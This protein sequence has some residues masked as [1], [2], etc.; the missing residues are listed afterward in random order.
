MMSLNKD[1]KYAT[2][3]S[4]SSHIWFPVHI[5]LFI[6][7]DGGYKD[8]PRKTIKPSFLPNIVKMSPK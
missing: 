3:Y 7:A 2:V 1:N 5:K 6:T 4:G 8:F